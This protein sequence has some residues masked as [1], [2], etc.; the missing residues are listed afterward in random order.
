[1][2]VE[3]QN[4]LPASQF[5]LRMG[6]QLQ[7][8]RL[9]QRGFLRLPGCQPRASIQDPGKGPMMEMQLSPSGARRSF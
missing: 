5:L 2:D 3:A 1:L 9:T 4:D 6:D 7:L 8:H